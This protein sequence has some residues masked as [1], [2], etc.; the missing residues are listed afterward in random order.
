[1]AKPQYLV[2]A[3]Q[4]TIEA[5]RLAEDGDQKT[6]VLNLAEAVEWILRGFDSHG[7]LED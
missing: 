6:A 7:V 4:R 3:L 2:E 1:M 5:R